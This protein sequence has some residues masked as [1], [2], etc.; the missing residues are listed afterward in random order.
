M[1]D[2]AATLYRLWSEPRPAEPV[3]P[4]VKADRGQRSVMSAA[5]SFVVFAHVRSNRTDSRR[6]RQTG[7]SKGAGRYESPPP[8]FDDRTQVSTWWVRF[9][10]I[11]QATR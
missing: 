8:T 7:K 6:I 11:D 1:P 2:R 3:D 9:K 4:E 10:F 5:R